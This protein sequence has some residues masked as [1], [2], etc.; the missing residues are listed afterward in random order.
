MPETAVIFGASVAVHFFVG[1]R[2]LR[3]SPP[4]CPY[5]PECLE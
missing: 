5:S 1:P 2:L 4:L 3:L